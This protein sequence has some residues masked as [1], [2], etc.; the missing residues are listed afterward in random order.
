MSDF[1]AHL[2]TFARDNLPPDDQW[3]AFNL[4]LPELDYPARMNCATELLDKMVASG[5][6]ERPLFYTTSDRSPGPTSRT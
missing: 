5:H 1:S 3:P 6:G 2:D 4:D